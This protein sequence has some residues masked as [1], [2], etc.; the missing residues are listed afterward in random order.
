[1]LAGHPLVAEVAVAGTPSEEWGEVVTAWVVADGP[2]PT[3]DE[4]VAFTAADPR[5][6]QAAPGGPGGG[7]AAPQCAG[8]GGPEPAP[9]VTR[10]VG[11]KTVAGARN[12]PATRVRPNDRLERA[13]AD[14]R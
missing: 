8:Q 14:D 12:P 5:P 6:L 10:E 13:L 1:M 4:L 7:G 2:A 11:C 3:A 9:A